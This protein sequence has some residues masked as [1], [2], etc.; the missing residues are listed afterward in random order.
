MLL[1][2]ELF[3][4]T[5]EYT[6][7]ERIFKSFYSI[8][9]DPKLLEEFIE[10]QKPALQRSINN[11]IKAESGELLSEFTENTEGFNFKGNILV[12][13]HSRY[14]PAFIHKHTFFEIIVMLSGSCINCIDDQEYLLTEGDICIIAP[15]EYHTLKDSND[16]IIYN[17]LIKHYNFSDSFSSFLLQ[18]NVLSCFFM[19]S[20]YSYNYQK[21]ITFHTK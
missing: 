3:E 9:N 18:S 21:F 7:G 6:S 14:C 19:Q 11:W 13:H 2:D 8:K 5:K 10:S 17:V 16:S 4:I 15:G 1:R 12:S 20:L